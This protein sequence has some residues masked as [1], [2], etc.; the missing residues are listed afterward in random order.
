M[1]RGSGV[2]PSGKGAHEEGAELSA[3]SP[4]ESWA[5]PE[6]DPN[7]SSPAYRELL[8]AYRRLEAK[9]RRLE[10][11]MATAAHE[12]KTPMSIV[13]GYLDVLLSGQA[14]P[15]SERQRAILE[16]LQANCGRLQEFAQE[17]LTYS[18]LETGTL[19]MKFESGDLIACLAEVYEFWIT[20]FQEKSVALYFPVNEKLEPFHFD[21]HKVQR[22]VSNLLENAFKFTPLGGTVWLTAEPYFW[23]R[24]SRQEASLT[25]ERREKDGARV[26]A[27]R[28][29]V[30]DTGP[31]IPPEYQQEIFDD[32][33]KLDAGEA[34]SDGIGLGLAIVRRLVQAHAGKIWVESEPG[35]GSRFCFLLPLQSA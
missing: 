26:N 4:A 3:A 16:D 7:L 6:T 20:R 22:V 30:S 27:I 14:G 2:Y 1:S 12:L 10:Q 18:G 19:S 15:V 8:E 5:S 11:A 32:F 29:C 21:Y 25:E 24:R 9:T 17:F 35:S 34:K 13:V 28:V 23:E 33:V 31:G